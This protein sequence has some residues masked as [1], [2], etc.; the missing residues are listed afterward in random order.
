MTKIQTSYWVMPTDLNPFG[1]LFGGT[2]MSWMDKAAALCA[3][4]HTERNCVTLFVDQI[5]FHSPVCVQEVVELEAEVVDEG[6][7]SVLIHV[8]A[9]KR[10]STEN[11]AVA[12]M[13]AE[14]IFKFVALD[15]KG[16]PSDRWV[17][18]I[19]DT[20]LPLIDRF[21]STRASEAKQD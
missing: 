20:R 17:K 9:R 2:M 3:M 7:T 15:S 10:K 5:K 19:H 1:N 14:S 4:K 12:L 8:N 11:P 18:R 13:V 21:T 16:K 6:M